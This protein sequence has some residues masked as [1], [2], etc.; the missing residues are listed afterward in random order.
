MRCPVCVETGEKSTVRGGGGTKTLLGGGGPY[1]DEDDVYHQHDPNRV[2]SYYT[3]SNN[4]RWTIKS[5]EP[6]PAESCDYGKGEGT[7]TRLED[8]QPRQGY[9]V[10][11]PAKLS[12]TLTNKT[13]TTP[14]SSD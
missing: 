1:W 8:I 14:A 6:C 9:I 5:L 10:A 13:L 12:S 7:V 4:H 2:T 11:G 3:C